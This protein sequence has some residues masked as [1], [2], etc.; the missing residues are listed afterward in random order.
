VI[1]DESVENFS[2]NVEKLSSSVGFSWNLGGVCSF[3][4]SF[5]EITVFPTIFPTETEEIY[6]LYCRF[7]KE[8]STTCAK[9]I[10]GG[11]SL[12]GKRKKQS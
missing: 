6:L 8:F 5:A 2:E 9:L 10:G 1:A 7:S 11:M 3:F 12:R 4:G